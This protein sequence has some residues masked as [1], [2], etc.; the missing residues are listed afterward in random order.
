VPESGV[1][2]RAPTFLADWAS[3][4]P[5]SDPIGYLFRHRFP[6]RWLRIHS[7][8]ES[9][10]YAESEGEW[11]QLLDRQNR[12]LVDQ[13]GEV[14]VVQI[15]VNFIEIRSPLFDQFVFENIGTF[16]DRDAETVF[17]SFLITTEWRYGAFDA[18]LRDV[19]NDEMRAFVVGEDRI[20]APY[21]GGM[22][23]IVPDTAERDRWRTAYGPWL[24]QR[25]D[26]L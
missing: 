10:R 17:Q 16:I 8:P 6:D 20:V 12:V 3:R 13:F 1:M 5:Q 9:K 24:S 23:L 11:E 2:M 21:D 14:S 26:G 25:E 18:L 15:V 7:L 4:Y 22:D 19:A